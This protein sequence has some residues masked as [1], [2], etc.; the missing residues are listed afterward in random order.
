MISTSAN[1][2][3]DK[4]ESF[5]LGPNFVEKRMISYAVAI[6]QEDE[7]IEGHLTESEIP[8]LPV[9]GNNFPKI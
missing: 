3:S 4:P 1:I 8:S 2:L 7:K 5:I 9:K 6:L